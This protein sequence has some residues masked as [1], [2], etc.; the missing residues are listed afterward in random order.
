M[1]LQLTAA[2][3]HQITPDRHKTDEELTTTRETRCGMKQQPISLSTLSLMPSSAARLFY[4]P[5]KGRYCLKRSPLICGATAAPVR[6]TTSWQRLLRPPWTR[7]CRTR[8][9]KAT[10]RSAACTYRPYSRNPV[11][12]SERGFFDPS[13]RSRVGQIANAGSI[14]KTVSGPTSL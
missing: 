8:R 1:N 6:L 3:R 13:S 7:C 4:R 5:R 10:Y 12:K 14:F 9:V 2:N 11:C